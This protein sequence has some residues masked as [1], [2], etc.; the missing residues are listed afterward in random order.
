MKSQNNGI[1]VLVGLLLLAL[2]CFWTNTTIGQ[3]APTKE[4]LM[5]T[6]TFLE[7]PT[8]NSMPSDIQ[9]QLSTSTGP[10]EYVATY[11]SGGQMRFDPDRTFSIVFSNRFQVGDYLKA[12]AYAN[13]EERVLFPE[14]H[15]I[16]N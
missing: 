5:G 11:Y 14:L 3:Q 6:W 7:I 8:V 16:K 4:M 10:Q 13:L 15:F 2:L 12:K 1:K 9:Q